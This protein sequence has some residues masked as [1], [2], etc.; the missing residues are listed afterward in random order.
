MSNLVKSYEVRYKQLL[1]GSKELYVGELETIKELL[2]QY[3]LS[4]ME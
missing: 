4:R 2:N 1:N 3:L